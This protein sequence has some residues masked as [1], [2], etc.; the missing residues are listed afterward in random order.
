MKTYENKVSFKCK[1]VK[2]ETCPA[3]NLIEIKTLPTH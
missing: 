2:M 3:V 1:L